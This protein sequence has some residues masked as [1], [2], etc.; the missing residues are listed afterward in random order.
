MRYID[1]VIPTMWLADN[2]VDNIKSYC[3]S[4]YVKK[5][6]VIDN[7]KSLR[8]NLDILNDPKIDIVSYGRNIFVNPAWNEG[9]LRTDSDVLCLLN[10][11]VTVDIEVFEK[12]SSL[13]N[14]DY[15]IIGVNLR[16]GKDN[17]TIG[18]LPNSIAIKKLNYDRTKPIGGQAWAFGICMFVKR[19]SYKPVPSLYQ[20]W[21][22][23]DYLVQNSNNVYTMQTGLI[24]GV[25]SK[26]IATS[27]PND[28][29]AKRIQL[30]T[31]NAYKFNHFENNKQWDILKSNRFTSKD[32]FEKEFQLAKTTPSDINENVYILNQLAKECSHVTEMGVRTGVSTRAFLA[33]DV[34]LVSYDVVLDSEVGKL[35]QL[36]KQ[37]GKSVDYVKAD[38]LK[39]EIEETD[40]LFI[41]T[42]HTYEQLKQELELHADKS[43]KYL[44]F[45]DTYT[46]GLKGEDRRDNRGLLTAIIEFMIQHPQ[47]RFKIHK[48]N[49]NG[50]TV[51][52]R[53]SI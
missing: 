40:L 11:D 13:E 22:G 44:V 29:I 49:N 52:E 24:T 25:I 27:K 42:L 4:P 53:T 16:S 36:A 26:T 9:Y 8:P 10:D 37:K 32:I 31:K 28:D 2:I 48:V 39:I 45:H 35:F 15:D 50:L 14:L 21:F 1:I 51:L 19:S 43:R 5:V 6:V 18:T 34:R 41:D 12:I 3:L 30:D 23:D 20:V 17:D 33:T 46:F 47:W 7:N 38:V